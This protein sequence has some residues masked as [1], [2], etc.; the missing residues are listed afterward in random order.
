M[1]G[2][3]IYCLRKEK[4]VVELISREPCLVIEAGYV[5]DFVPRQLKYRVSFWVATVDKCDY[6]NFNKLFNL[7][8]EYEKAADKPAVE[9]RISELARNFTFGD[10]IVLRTPADKSP[11]KFGKAPVKTETLGQGDRTQYSF[12]DL[13]KVAGIPFTEVSA[14]IG[15]TAFEFRQPK[16][17]PG[18]SMLDPTAFWPVEDKE[19]KELAARIASGAK[20]DAQK[21]KSLLD[22][23][24]PGKNIK[25][26]EAV[27][28]RY[29]VKQTLKQGFGQCWD[30]SDV[31]VS[32]CR[33]SGVP[34]RQVGG[35]LYGQCGHI[36]AEVYIDGKGW[37]YVDPTAGSPCGVY[38]VP[39]FL[40][41]DGEM[42]IVYVTIP[43]LEI[44][45][46]D[47]LLR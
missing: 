47:Q 40:T 11:Y 39:F 10:S 38:H 25:Y 46:K 24:V 12:G 9:K 44:A 16:T 34:C 13:T 43:K 18:Q 4:Q 45:E 36:W 21:V 7:L 5:L 14:E 29:G 42:P 6:P 27:G 23:L 1:K 31:F 22:W 41:E 33:A 8:L 3:P 35:W 32:L 26:G 15:V 2:N 37:Q 28:T 19:V 17:K 20:T 30:F